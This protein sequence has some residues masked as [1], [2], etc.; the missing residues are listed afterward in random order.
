MK[1]N[2]KKNIWDNKRYAAELKKMKQCKDLLSLEKEY[3][4]LSILKEKLEK[5]LK[6]S[7]SDGIHIDQTI[8]DFK[9]II[10][11]CEG[12]PFVETGV[13]GDWINVA[14]Y[15]VI[16]YRNIENNINTISPIDFIKSGEPFKSS[17]SKELSTEYLYKCGKEMAKG[18]SI[19]IFLQYLKGLL[20]KDNSS[21]VQADDEYLMDLINENMD[22][23]FVKNDFIKR[24]QIVKNIIPEKDF[25]ETEKK[26][27]PDEHYIVR[28]EVIQTDNFGNIKLVEPVMGVDY[29]KFMISAY[30]DLKSGNNWPISHYIKEARLDE[31]RSY[32]KTEMTRDID[33]IRKSV[34]AHL[35]QGV[36]LVLYEN[37]LN[38]KL[39]KN[40]SRYT[41]LALAIAYDLK[42]QGMNAPRLTVN[43]IEDMGRRLG[44]GKG[45]RSLYTEGF[46][47]LD[48]I[49]A[50]GRTPTKNHIENAIQYLKEEDEQNN[51]KAIEKG[52]DLYGSILK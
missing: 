30:N 28:I 7:V 18:A 16:G 36:A 32:G 5:S 29:R 10:K 31:A 35:K 43:Q 39:I 50:S 1:E 6:K 46:N 51:I 41:T 45:G 4:H 21:T 49:K 37:W 25:I 20:N 9:E 34:I 2:S 12:K 14:Y 40:H 26:R 48:N 42:M 3:G 22:F 19:A 24:Y 52:Y 33:E 15:F 8:T 23:T 11:R 47:K 38:E 44:C 17:I 13:K 27:I